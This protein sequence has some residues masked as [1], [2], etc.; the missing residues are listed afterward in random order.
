MIELVI[1]GLNETINLDIKK[2]NQIIYNN[3]SHLL[4][5]YKYFDILIK[6]KQELEKIKL[7]NKNVTSKDF[8]LINL[9]DIASIVEE[10]KYKRTSLLF[11]HMNSIITNISL[12]EK[13]FLE[14]VIEKTFNNIKS[15]LNFDINISCDIDMFK[16]FNNHVD[17]LPKIKNEEIINVLMVILSQTIVTQLNK[18]F[19]IFVNKDLINMDFS[20]FDNVYIFDVTNNH[21]VKDVNI[22]L[23][24]NAQN[25][26]YE[27]LFNTIKLNWP[28]DI[29]DKELE[30]I[31]D[32]YFNNCYSTDN[33]I[34]ET[35]NLLIFTKIINKLMNIN[36]DV[37]YDESIISNTIKSFLISFN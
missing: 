30:K 12:D 23:S 7:G 33:F 10:L 32:Y 26:D 17:F 25:F 13:L 21:T 16:L 34:A 3:K 35:E 14:E 36:Q 15:N 4:S 9:M 18:T 27:M 5:F 22:L 28:L 37:S 24:N 8:I 2:H 11:E 20:T 1:N 6:E 31:I 19:I 29:S